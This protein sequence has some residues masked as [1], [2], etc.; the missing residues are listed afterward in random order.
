[1]DLDSKNLWNF[2]L[3]KLINFAYKKGYEVQISNKNDFIKSPLNYNV[4]DLQKKIIKIYH[5]HCD[6]YKIYLIL[7]ELGHAALNDEYDDYKKTCGYGQ[8]FFSKNSIT[9]Q[10]S[11]IEEEFEAW[12]IGFDI[13]K[14]IKIKIDKRR[15]EQ[16]KSQCLVTYTRFFLRKI[17]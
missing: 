4:V 6:E 1:M 9:N 14:E 10:I 3:K 13:A 7:H 16:F 12:K 5:G 11:I 2:R 17:Q 8:I 15:F